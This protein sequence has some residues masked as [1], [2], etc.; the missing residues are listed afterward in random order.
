MILAD[1]TFHFAIDYVMY[2]AAVAAAGMAFAILVKIIRKSDLS[3]FPFWIPLMVAGAGAFGFGIADMPGDPKLPD[4]PSLI[5]THTDADNAKKAE[6]VKAHYEYLDRHPAE[7][8]QQDPRTLPRWADGLLCVGGAGLFLCGLVLMICR[9]YEKYGKN[10]NSPLI[11]VKWQNEL[12]IIKKMIIDC[13]GGPTNIQSDWQKAV[14]SHLAGAGLRDNAAKEVLDKIAADL[15]K[16]FPIAST[17]WDKWEANQKDHGERLNAIHNKLREIDTAIKTCEVEIRS[18]DIEAIAKAVQLKMEKSLQSPPGLAE[19][20]KLAEA[21]AK[22]V[23]D[24]VEAVAAI[25]L[26]KYPILPVKEEPKTG[27]FAPG[28][29]CSGVFQPA[30]VPPSVRGSGS[31]GGGAWEPPAK[32][33]PMPTPAET[34]KP[35]EWVKWS[36]S[37]KPESGG[38]VQVYWSKE[39]PTHRTLNNGPFYVMNIDGNLLN[40]RNEVSNPNK[41]EIVKNTMWWR[42]VDGKP[43]PIKKEIERIDGWVRW[44]DE[45]PQVGRKMRWGDDK[46]KPNPHYW[47]VCG[48]VDVSPNFLRDTDSIKGNYAVWWKYADDPQAD[49]LKAEGWIP[50]AERLPDYSH[51]V[52]VFGCDVTEAY[53]YREGKT[54]C[55]KNHGVPGLA[56]WQDLDSILHPTHWKEIA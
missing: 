9:L 5:K 19:L 32:A 1:Y 49:K 50:V 54:W 37:C 24:L 10:P 23:A 30:F 13:V 12:D 36:D 35:S 39:P 33:N 43:T 53:W 8:G 6:I 7:F 17:R 21:N 28:V 40:E 26:V 42:Y 55:R 48:D 38:K 34:S 15:N 16:A 31:I 11:A 4:P 52:K 14:V 2:P 18:N 41:D 46:D 25:A 22:Q 44:R 56:E 47:W 20:Q 45:K 3:A 51:K 27:F 29:V